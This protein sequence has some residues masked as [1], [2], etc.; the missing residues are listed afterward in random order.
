MRE[1]AKP[2]TYPVPKAYA[3]CKHYDVPHYAPNRWSESEILESEIN[4]IE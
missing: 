2:S 3:E 4:V 1:R